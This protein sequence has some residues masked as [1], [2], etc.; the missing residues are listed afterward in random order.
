MNASETMLL[1]FNLIECY[2]IL[3]IQNCNFEKNKDIKKNYI[4]ISEI[5]CYAKTPCSTLP[6]QLRGK[7]LSHLFRLSDLSLIAANKI[8]KIDDNYLTFEKISCFIFDRHSFI[9][10]ISTRSITLVS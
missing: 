5:F 8:I 3:K 9:E 2:L 6:V 1:Q 4:H 10:K 7:V